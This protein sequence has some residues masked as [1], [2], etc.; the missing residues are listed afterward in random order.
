MYQVSSFG[1]IK[2]LS[3]I[4]RAGIKNNEFIKREEKIL[5][6]QDSTKKYSQVRI[7]KN[8]KGKTIKVHRLVAETF[9]PNENNLPQVNHID[10][11]KKNNRVDNLEWCDQEYN[12][13]H[14][15]DIG[16]RDREKLR[17]TMKIIGKSKKGL[18]SR[19]GKK[20]A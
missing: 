8:K 2:S 20:Y 14:S 4:T 15:Y 12:M 9:I 11:N 3:R 16:L 13:K 1:R 19:W 18:E 5:K 10:G 17:N 7:Y 6:Q